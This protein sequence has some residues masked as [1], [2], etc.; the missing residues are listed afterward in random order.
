[1][2]EKIE[3]NICLGSSCFSRGNGKT[4]QVI[5]G[6]LEEKKLKEKVFFRGELCTGNCA[7]GPILKI[8]D[9]MYEAL[10]SDNSIELLKGALALD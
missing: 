1:M 2:S 4:L 10:D 3:I 9:E 6:F 5:K 8:G 7:N